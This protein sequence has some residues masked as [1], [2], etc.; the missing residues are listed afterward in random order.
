MFPNAVMLILGLGP[1]AKIF[2][3]GFDMQVFALGLGVT[4]LVEITVFC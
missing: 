3:L 1:K 2:D 4:D